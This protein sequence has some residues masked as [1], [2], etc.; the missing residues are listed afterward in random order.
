MY[1]AFLALPV[2]IIHHIIDTIGLQFFRYSIALLYLITDF[3]LVWKN[4]NGKLVIKK[5]INTVLRKRVFATD[6]IAP[7]TKITEAK[8]QPDN[9]TSAHIPA[10]RQEQPDNSMPGVILDSTGK[11]QPPSI[12]DLA[13][14]TTQEQSYTFLPGFIPAM[15]Q[16]R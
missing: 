1:S 2:E 16:E 11:E 6:T 5:F 10:P 13:P 4:A 12:P 3:L 15:D 7:P 9:A 14:I 8:G